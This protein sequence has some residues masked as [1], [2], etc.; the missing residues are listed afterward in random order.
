MLIINENELLHT[1]SCQDIIEHHGVRGMKWGQRTK[2]WGSAAGRAVVNNLRHPIIS[3]KGIVASRKHSILGTEFGTT[4]SLEFRNRYVK[5]MVAAKKQ[6]K[7]DKK[8]ANT[9]YSEEVGKLG[10]KYEK[11]AFYAKRDKKNGETRKDFRNRVT[12]SGKEFGNEHSKLNT[13]RKNSIKQ[14][15]AKRKTAAMMAGGSY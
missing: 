3:N 4:R 5:D 7:K 6:Y 11:T 9:K 14:A 2:R 12:N 1:D 13:E 10:K 15:K 8:Q